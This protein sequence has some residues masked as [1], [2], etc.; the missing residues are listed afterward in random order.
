MPPKKQKKG[1]EKKVPASEQKVNFTGPPYIGKSDHRLM[2]KFEPKEFVIFGWSN[3][4]VS[5]SSKTAKLYL[6]L[7]W[8]NDEKKKEPIEA[9][10]AK[11]VSGV[12]NLI[13][14]IHEF[15]KQTLKTF[16]DNKGTSPDCNLPADAIPMLKT[17]G[18]RSS[19]AVFPDDQKTMA[20]CF[21]KKGFKITDRDSVHSF[22]KTTGNSDFAVTLTFNTA[23]YRYNRELNNITFSLY[24]NVMDILWYEAG[25]NVKLRRLQDDTY[26]KFNPMAN[27]ILYE[28]LFRRALTLT[29]EREKEGTKMEA[30]DETAEE[31][32][33]GGEGEDLDDSKLKQS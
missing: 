22:V 11:F 10:N 1:H 18:D 3:N 31:E 16:I 13:N 5:T 15:S 2:V 12:K 14:E 29:Q 32:Q 19:Y 21:Q 17:F 24:N 6:S 9:P 20:R 7:E 33:G 23:E 4:G 8:K 26:K 27:K 28:E 30:M 25:Q